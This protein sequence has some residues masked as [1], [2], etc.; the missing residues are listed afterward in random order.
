MMEE[1]MMDAAPALE[2]KIARFASFLQADP[3]NRNLLLDLGDLY[4]QAGQF[5]AALR[6]FSQLCTLEPAVAVAQSRLA[7]VYLSLHRFDDAAA[8]LAALV[9]ADAGNGPLQYN[10][11]L[12]QYYQGQYAAAAA[13]FQAADQAGAGSAD[14][15]KYLSHC[16][17]HEGQLEEA[18]A[19][20]SQWRA[21]TI[22]AD[23][24]ISGQCADSTAYLALLEFDSGNREAA[25]ELAGAVLAVDPTNL[26]ANAVMGG[27]AL[28]QQDIA[29]AADC[30]QQILA[31]RPDYGRA[32]LGLGLT[33]LHDNNNDKALDAMTEATR[34]MPGHAGTEVALGW[35]RVI[36]GDGVGAEA[37]FRKAIELD[38]NFAESHG[39]LA[40]AL[41]MQNR[42]EEA[43]KTIKA[44]DRLDPANFGSV[45]GKALLLRADGRAELAQGLINRAL[46]RAPVTGVNPLLENVRKYYLA[47]TGKPWR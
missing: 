7:N 36:V 13:S 15:Y 17:H 8:V 2:A 37:T 19:A 34:Q 29:L 39:G 11:G 1:N 43:Q 38:R 45:Y 33:Y 10:L 28:E 32:W 26:D 42:I 24:S 16:L 31:Q 14:L 3:E 47:R 27:A 22:G 5:E 6:C 12:A 4:H 40:V 23:G 41:I 20:A 18:V 9:A 25:L 21:A 30:F 35:S 44:A 46:E